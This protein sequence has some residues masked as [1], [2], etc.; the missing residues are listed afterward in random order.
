[1]QA[2][3]W[4]VYEMFKREPLIRHNGEVA[5]RRFSSYRAATQD[6]IDAELERRARCAADKAGREAF[7]ARQDVMDAQAVRSSIEFMEPGDGLVD[8]LSPEEWAALRKR[9]EDVA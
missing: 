1:M 4:T 3:Q 5:P 8:R 9:L 7:A 2:R 6:E